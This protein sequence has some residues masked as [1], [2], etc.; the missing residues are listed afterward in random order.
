MK[1]SNLKAALQFLGLD[2]KG[3]KA[4]L[5]QRLANAVVVVAQV[6]K[7]KQQLNTTKSKSKG[8]GKKSYQQNYLQSPICQRAWYVW[9]QSRMAQESKPHAA[10]VQFTTNALRDGQIVVGVS[11][12]AQIAT[13]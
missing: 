4:A 10:V 6:S 12:G 1:V 8:V 2:V 11:F 9:P 3:K 13:T 7:E 5:L